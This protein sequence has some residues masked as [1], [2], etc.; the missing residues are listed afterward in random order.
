MVQ[1]RPPFLSVADVTG[2]H[3]AMGAGFATV[4]AVQDPQP[5]VTFF[6]SGE[7]G[8]YVPAGLTDVALI[9]VTMRD[10]QPEGEQARQ[11]VANLESDGELLGW[12]PLPIQRD[13]TFIWQGQTFRVE[14]VDP[15]RYGTVLARITVTQKRQVA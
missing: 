14:V 4:Q 9:R 5:V 12:A 11:G 3:E 10:L 6:R 13:D 8:R 15:E 2:I 1:Q 7:N